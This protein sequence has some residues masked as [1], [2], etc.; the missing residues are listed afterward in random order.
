ML[1]LG[2]GGLFS[3]ESE[4]GTPVR[5]IF[6]APSGTKGRSSATARVVRRSELRLSFSPCYSLQFKMP[7][8]PRSRR[9]AHKDRSG[10]AD[11]LVA[12]AVGPNRSAAGGAESPRFSRRNASLI[13]VT[14][15]D[16]CAPRWGAR[17]PLCGWETSLFNAL[18]RR[19]RG[20]GSRFPQ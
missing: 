19:L 5:P 12:D 1:A 10:R 13:L 18:A 17:R 16:F 2:L 4:K 6:Q 9:L 8:A 14:L 15:L 20:L 3:D 11:F 7:V